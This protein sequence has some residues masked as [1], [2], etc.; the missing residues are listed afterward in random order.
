MVRVIRS[1]GLEDADVLAALSMLVCAWGVQPV[2]LDIHCQ[3][4]S[5]QLLIHRKG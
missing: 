4:F 5:D 1:Y 3:L 2:P